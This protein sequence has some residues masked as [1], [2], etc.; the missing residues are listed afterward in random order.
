MY[1]SAKGLA[2]PGFYIKYFTQKHRE[3]T[4]KFRLFLCVLCASVRNNVFI[5]YNRELLFPIMSF[6]FSIPNSLNLI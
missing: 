1:N 6:Y 4:L 5:N 3:K 2:H